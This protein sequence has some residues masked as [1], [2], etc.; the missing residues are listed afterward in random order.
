M[1]EHGPGAPVS[2]FGPGSRL[3]SSPIAWRPGGRSR[4]PAKQRPQDEF[5]GQR[6]LW[7]CT[8]RFPAMPAAFSSTA[9]E[10][11]KSR[12]R[13]PSART[14]GGVQIWHASMS[15]P[16]ARTVQLRIVTNVRHAG[17]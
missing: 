1:S 15:G 12:T 5:C 17:Q 13:R 3:H 4:G 8:A 11:R 9:W 10:A 16:A 6:P 2:P 7:A 14:A